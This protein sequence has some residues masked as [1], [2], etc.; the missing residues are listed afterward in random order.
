MNLDDLHLSS[1]RQAV[2][3]FD[4]EVNLSLWGWVSDRGL[5]WHSCLPLRCFPA[6]NNIEE[7]LSVTEL[8]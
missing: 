1:T 6:M 5:A 3:S 4:F 7:F 8:W 2:A